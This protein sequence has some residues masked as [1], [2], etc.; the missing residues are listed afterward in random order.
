[1]DERGKFKEDLVNDVL[2][3]LNLYEAAHL[4]L[5]REGILD[6]AIAFTT[7]HLESTATKVNP[8]LAEQIAHAL[9]RPI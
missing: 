3:M 7:S 9:N 4:H 5:P 2:G 1:M 8:L 6:E